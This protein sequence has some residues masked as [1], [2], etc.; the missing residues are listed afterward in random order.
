MM[1]KLVLGRINSG[2]TTYIQTLIKDCVRKGRAELFCLCPSSF[3]L[4]AKSV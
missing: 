3:H 4:K 1:L 2:K